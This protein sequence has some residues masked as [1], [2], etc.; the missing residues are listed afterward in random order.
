MTTEEYQKVLH[1]IQVLD[2]AD[3]L[4]VDDS[5]YMHHY[6]QLYDKPEDMLNSPDEPCLEFRWVDG[7]GEEYCSSFTPRSLAM[8]VLG[9][10]TI[11][12]VMMA[13]ECEDDELASVLAWTLR[14]LSFAQ[15]GARE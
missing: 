3:V 10:E 14:P 7:E 11:P 13:I 8:A 1:I 9:D 12:H 15:E 6:F 4:V 2:R 5:P